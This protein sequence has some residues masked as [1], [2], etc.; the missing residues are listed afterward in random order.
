MHHRCKWLKFI[1]FAAVYKNYIQK[2]LAVILLG[3]FTINTIP[4]EFIHVFAGHHDTEDQPCAAGDLTIS[5]HHRHC[6][7]LQL[8]VEPY[9]QY[10]T[11]YV[12]PVRR[13]IWVFNPLELPETTY[14][15]YRD[16][17]PRAPPA[18]IA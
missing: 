18:M 2:V 7:F 13:V 16:L 12:S 10:I 6:D 11:D 3:V 1:T 17:S 14:T 9:E 15:P 8:G 5:E 4:R